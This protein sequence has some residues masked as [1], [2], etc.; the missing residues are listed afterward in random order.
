MHELTPRQEHTLDHHFSHWQAQLKELG[1]KKP[2]VGSRCK[3]AYRSDNIQPRYVK[4]RV[5]RV[6]QDGTYRVVLTEE[7]MKPEH[8]SHVDGRLLH[9][10]VGPMPDDVVWDIQQD[11]GLHS[12]RVTPHSEV[13]YR[14]Q[15]WK[16]HRRPPPAPR[17]TNDT[18]STNASATVRRGVRQRRVDSTTTPA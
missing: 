2:K 12:W 17:Q 9:R 4:V 14:Y 13:A 7:G 3:M 16:N 18:P 15:Y 8:F 10:D 1:R 6:H 5:L 11:A